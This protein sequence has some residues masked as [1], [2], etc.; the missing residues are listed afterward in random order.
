MLIAIHDIESKGGD[1]IGEEEG[2]FKLAHAFEST[3]ST[4]G[5][6]PW[7]VGVSDTVSSVGWYANPLR[8]PYSADN[9][10][11]EIGRH[12]ASPGGPTQVEYCARWRFRIKLKGGMPTITLTC[13]TSR[14]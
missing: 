7:F 14:W 9:P 13:Q 3:F 6:K 4:R 2:Y 12:G 8:V 1:R 11:I 5:C 10:D